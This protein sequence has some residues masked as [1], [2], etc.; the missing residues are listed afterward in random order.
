MAQRDESIYSPPVPDPLRRHSL[1]AV[2]LASTLPLSLAACAQLG[3][4]GT[5]TGAPSADYAS[6]MRQ[7]LRSFAGE[8]P[9]YYFRATP[10]GNFGVGSIYLDDVSDPTL[11]HVE[12]SWFL[13]GPD[14]WL[15]PSLTRSQRQQ[16]LARLVVEGSLGAFDLSTSTSRSLNAQAGMAILSAMVGNAS[17]DYSNGVETSFQA[18]EV[19]DRRL[20]WAEFETALQAGLITPVVARV[21]RQG[22]FVVAAADVVLLGYRAQVAVDDSRNPTLSATLRTN[23]LMPQRSSA[24]AG[25]SVAEEAHGRFLVTAKQP[26]VAAILFKRPPPQSK[27]LGEHTPRPALDAWPDANISHRTIDAIESRVLSGPR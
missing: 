24:T 4:S 5:S 21:V 2:T 23:I 19:R 9:S 22:Q 25:F 15:A 10:I 8:L 6:T 7:A 27:D 13:G 14:S 3:L 12:S 20:N 18:S 11:K 17:I 26:V 16:W 1:I